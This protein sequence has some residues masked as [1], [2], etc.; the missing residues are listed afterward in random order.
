MAIDAPADGPCFPGVAVATQPSPGR[1]NCAP[2]DELAGT[3]FVSLLGNYWLVR[4]RRLSRS[5]HPY[6]SSI[7]ASQEH[8]M[9]PLTDW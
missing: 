1:G 5:R 9:Q 6:D 7:S 4:G 2:E 3:D 8:S